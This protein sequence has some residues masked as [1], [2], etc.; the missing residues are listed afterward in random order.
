MTSDRSYWQLELPAITQ[1]PNV[2]F[3]QVCMVAHIGEKTNPDNKAIFKYDITNQTK[4]HKSGDA[5][6]LVVGRRFQS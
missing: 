3:R 1:C 6:N 2:C 4:N 5:L